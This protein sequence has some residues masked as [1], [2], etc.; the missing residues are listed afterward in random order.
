MLPNGKVFMLTKREA[1]IFDY[2]IAYSKT[3]PNLGFG[4]T[5]AETAANGVKILPGVGF[6]VSANSPAA[7]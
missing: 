6:D 7:K 5:L 4:Q 1:M 2:N 3:D